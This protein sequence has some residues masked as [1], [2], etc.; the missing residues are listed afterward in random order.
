M[1]L[2]YLLLVSFPSLCCVQFQYLSLVLYYYSLFD[3]ILFLFCYN[4]KACFLIRDRKEYDSRWERRWGRA[5]GV[6]RESIMRVYQRRKKLFSIKGNKK[7]ATLKND[8][9]YQITLMNHCFRIIMD[10]NRI[11]RWR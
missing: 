10:K 8:S 6:E 3:S 5:R 4:S 1:E 11:K 9:G 7:K 2:L